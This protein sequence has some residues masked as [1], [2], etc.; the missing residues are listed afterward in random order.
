MQYIVKLICQEPCVGIIYLTDLKW[1]GVK[2]KFRNLQKSRFRNF[3]FNLLNFYS[4]RD[5][6]IYNGEGCVFL[7]GLH[8]KEG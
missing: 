3:F 1:F 6:I 2:E 8:G 4:V 5:I 7:Q